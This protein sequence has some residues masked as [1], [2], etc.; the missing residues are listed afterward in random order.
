MIE[1]GI[2]DPTKVTRSAIQN[3]ASVAASTDF[4]IN[5][6]ILAQSIIKVNPCTRTMQGVESSY[7]LK[8]VHAAHAASRHCRSRILLFLVSNQRFGG[9]NHRCNR[10]RILDCA[11]G[12][13]GRI[14]DL[15]QAMY[16]IVDSIFVAQVSENA[17]TAVSLAFPVQNLMIAVSV[18]ILVIAPIPCVIIL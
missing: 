16:N 5:F 10:S 9:Q 13:L 3:A 8:S 12:N 18:V 6:S 7:F 1:L 14:D 2:V 11:S 17:L 4:K 15:V